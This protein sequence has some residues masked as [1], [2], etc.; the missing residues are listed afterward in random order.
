MNKEILEKV[1]SN[2]TEVYKTEPLF[3]DKHGRTMPSRDA[4]IDIINE[5]KKVVFPGYFDHNRAGSEE[6]YIG[7]EVMSVYSQLRQQVKAALYYSCDACPEC[8]LD[9]CSERI[10]DEFFAGLVEIQQMLL[11]DLQAGFDGDPAAKSKEEIIYSYPGLF[12]IFVYRIANRL[13]KANVPLIPRIMSEYAHGRTGIDINPGA[14]IG[15]YFFIDHGTG[16]VIGETTTVGNFVKVYQGVTLGALSTR[17]GQQLAGVKRHPTICDNVT[18]YAG[19]TILGGE[20][21][22]GENSI[23]GGNCFITQS[24]PA[25]SRVSAKPSELIV[26][27][28]KKKSNW[29]I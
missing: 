19:A 6:H 29:E 26:K 2:M 14:T 7:F 9:K 12:A 3:A 22:I 20:T 28:R 25:N 18:I 23:I 10:C 1:I 11:K 13:Y 5:L 27:E 21:V 17:S 4:I 24:V 8:D 15:E 16:V